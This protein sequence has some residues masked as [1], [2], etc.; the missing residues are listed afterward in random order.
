[1]GKRRKHALR[2]IDG[3]FPDASGGDKDD[4]EASEGKS[5]QAVCPQVIG[6]ETAITPLGGQQGW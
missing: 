1:M 3:V 5:S 4:D 6:A 2:K